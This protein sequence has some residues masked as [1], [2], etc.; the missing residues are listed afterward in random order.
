MNGERDTWSRIAKGR[1][2][3]RERK[4][5]KPSSARRTSVRERAEL[6]PPG[7][8]RGKEVRRGAARFVGVA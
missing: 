3:C 1:V 7:K 8:I 4:D 2:M 5:G 6:R